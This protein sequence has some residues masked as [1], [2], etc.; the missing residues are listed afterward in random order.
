MQLGMV[1]LGRMGA[2]MVRR[3]MRGGHAC[4]VYD[5]NP[6]AIP[7]L[8]KDG[9][10]GATTIETFVTKLTQPRAIWMMVPA[11]VVDATIERLL[12][13]LQPGDILIDG[14]NSHYADDIRRA[15]DLKPRGVAYIDV[16]TSG[17]VWG[18]DRGFCQ[19]IGGE[20][21]SVGHLDPIFDT[22]ARGTDAA[23]HTPGREHTPV[24]T[25]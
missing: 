17:G 1:G 12:P 8:E 6:A 22:L 11:A 3:L 14:G 16:G 21:A 23:P 19:M 2:G 9:A 15:E 24:A 20:P 5:V 7:P 25:P 4:V 13:H 10:T 18:C